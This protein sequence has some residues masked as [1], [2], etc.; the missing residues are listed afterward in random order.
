VTDQS[1]IPTPDLV[2]G[3]LPAPAPAHGIEPA[4]RESRTLLQRLFP[5]TA[6]GVT[7]EQGQ[8]VTRVT[9]AA[10]GTVLFFVASRLGYGDL[11]FLL[12]LV[13][14]LAAVFHLSF[15]SRHRTHFLWR[16]YAVILL[17]LAVATFLTAHFSGAGLAFYPLFLWVMIGNGLRYGQHHMQVA[18]LF[19]LLGFTGAMATSGFLWDQP[20][21]YLGLVG[22][23]VL[24]PKFFL[25]M[26]DR[27]AAANVE[28]KAQKDHAEFMATHDVLTG[29]PNRAYLHTR[30]QQSLARANRTGNEVAVA[31]IDLDSFKS[32]N[33]SFGHEYGDYLLTQVAEAMQKMVRDSDTVSRLG[34]DE[35]VVVIEDYNNGARI[36][37]V[38]ERLFSCVGRYYLI[39]EY[40]TYVTWSCGVVVYPHDGEDV[41]TLLKHA[42]TAMY[43]AKSR[44]PNNFVFYDAAMSAVVG[45]Q[46]ALRDE[47]RLALDRGQLEVYYQP[48]IDAVTGCVG[49][50]E[51]LLRWNHPDRGL[52]SPFGFIEVAEQSGLIN[53]IGDWVMREALK[54]AAIWQAAVDQP[55]SIHV[56]VSAH[57]LKQGDFVERVAAALRDAGLPACVLDLEMTESALIEDATRAESL[58]AS[59]KA[60]G[61]KIALDDFGTGFSSLSYLKTLPVDAIKIDKS[62]I[63][64]L[65]T[66]D[67]SAALVEAVLTLGERLDNDIVAE[68][69]ETQAQRDWLVEHGCRFLQGYYFSRPQPQARFL[70]IAGADQALVL[71]A[72]GAA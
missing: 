25:V 62:F 71:A 19:G 36:A 34:G 50:A 26:I 70:D 46:L 40:E 69:V 31:F 57:Q 54:T 21:V 51:A 3:P 52:L 20:G 29:L 58:L 44:G 30:M 59:L 8:A 35:F 27:L 16:R 13:Y 49:S 11:P 63:D 55:V 65:P 38:I 7:Q 2:A 4:R 28:L 6:E 17:D 37:R 61:V 47:L 12:A 67:R 5:Q 24:M 66:G 56:N 45:E 48:I 39:G 33:D 23:L 32:I 18:T 68:G 60:L 15:V 1:F 22:G 64:D 72:A 9:L 41:H 42:D 53:P 10:L 14:M 43:S